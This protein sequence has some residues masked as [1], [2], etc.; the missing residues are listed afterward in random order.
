MVKNTEVTKEILQRSSIAAGTAIETD[1]LVTIASGDRSK[2]TLPS[3][4]ANEQRAGQD[5]EKET[6]LPISTPQSASSILSVVKPICT[7]SSQTK[8]ETTKYVAI[9]EKEPPVNPKNI[10]EVKG[11][12]ISLHTCEKNTNEANMQLTVSGSGGPSNSSGV[13]SNSGVAQGN[14][15]TSTVSSPPASRRSWAPLTGS[16]SRNPISTTSNVG[17]ANSRNGVR[18]PQ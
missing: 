18:H 14:N 5:I 9:Q 2:D 11:A 1:Q 13:A 17:I 12:S 4:A 3:T 16:R 15:I 6:E 10:S 8:D 7:T